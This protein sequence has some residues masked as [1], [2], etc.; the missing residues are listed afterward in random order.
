M[1]YLNVIIL[2]GEILWHIATQ[3]FWFLAVVSLLLVM[4]GLTIGRSSPPPRRR[5]IPDLEV[6]I[7]VGPDAWA[8]GGNLKDRA[9]RWFGQSHDGEWAGQCADCRHKTAG[10]T[11]V[12]HIRSRG[13]SRRR[14]GRANMITGSPSPVT[15]VFVLSRGLAEHNPRGA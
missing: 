11:R 12:R 8:D 14:S 2:G 9:A 5:R 13:T 15:A 4:L 3:I 10:Q 1:D 7:Y 6:S